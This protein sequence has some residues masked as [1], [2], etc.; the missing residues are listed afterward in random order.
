M[1]E[2]TLDDLKSDYDALG[3]RIAA[4]EAKLPRILN[5]PSA[6]IELRAGEHYGG[7]ILNADGTLNYRIA[8]VTVNT[9][10]HDWSAAG[11]FAK[12]VGGK[13]PNR[14]EARLLLANCKPHLP[15]D[16]VFWLDDEYEGDASYAWYCFFH[17]GDTDVL[18]KSY[19]RQA[20]VVR[21]F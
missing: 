17:Y 13:R 16:G 6:S 5:I 9:K 14:A 12:S 8:L 18:H 4:Y 19:E 20:V 10:G 3:A 1:S 11:E 15:A 7:E 21:R 2:T